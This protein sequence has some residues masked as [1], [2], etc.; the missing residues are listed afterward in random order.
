MSIKKE[1]HWAELRLARHSNELGWTPPFFALGEPLGVQAGLHP[2][3]ELADLQAAASMVSFIDRM[4]LRAA[5]SLPITPASGPHEHRRHA[6]RAAAS[7]SGQA[8]IAASSVPVAV[9]GP[10]A[11]RPCAESVAPCQRCGCSSFVTY[12]VTSSSGDDG[13]G[14]E[15]VIL[16]PV[17]RFWWY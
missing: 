1:S 7:C 3:G 8:A 15:E 9:R 4:L 10:R 5:G 6:E 11:A 13:G 16:L 2:L 17:V 12:T 14:A